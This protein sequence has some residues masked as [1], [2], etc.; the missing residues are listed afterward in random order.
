[1]KNIVETLIKKKQTISTM[2][3]CTGG[4]LANE[5]TNIPNASMVFKFGAVTYSNEFK[6]KM[7]VSNE[8]ITKYGVYSEEV[9]KEMSYQ[10]NKYANSDYG[11]GITGKL[12]KQDN[13]NLSSEENIVYYAI[14][15]RKNKMYHCGKVVVTSN[16]R[17]INKKKVVEIVIEKLRSVI[18]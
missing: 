5:I 13:N 2:E 9:A 6:T 16:D 1:M 11:V 14:Y 4:Q 15:V 18:E 17:T 7:N 10:I 3:S 8:I 12:M